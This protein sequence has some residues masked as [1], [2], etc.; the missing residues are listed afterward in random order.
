[1]K[2][3]IKSL[4]FALMG[5]LISN[6]CANSSETGDELLDSLRE[7]I[8]KTS[9]FLEV[10]YGSESKSLVGSLRIVEMPVYG[11]VDYSVDFGEGVS[12]V[13]SFEWANEMAGLPKVSGSVQFHKHRDDEASFR[14]FGLYLAPT[15]YYKLSFN[16]HSAAHKSFR[17]WI[18]L[19]SVPFGDEMD[20]ILYII[21]LFEENLE[22]IKQ[23]DFLEFATQEL[24]RFP[25]RNW[26]FK[27]AGGLK[28][29]FFTLLEK[30]LS[31]NPEMSLDTD[32]NLWRILVHNY[33]ALSLESESDQITGKVLMEKLQGLIANYED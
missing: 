15:N 26:T 1:M 2:L 22:I 28:R 3:K 10:H 17:G 33:P 21:S 4:L 20:P 19:K 16:F 9:G 18:Q 11:K 27:E 29:V 12:I 30:S 7:Q 8:R 13:E 24:E 25:E 14:S 6:N 5:V 32:S 31:D 23:K